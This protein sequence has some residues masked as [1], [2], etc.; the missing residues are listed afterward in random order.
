MQDLYFDWLYGLVCKK[1]K[2]YKKL[3]GRLHE[4][5]FTWTI[6]L[7]DNRASDGIGLRYRFG[8]ECGIHP[9][10]IASE[11]DICCCSVLEMLVALV[12]RFERD[13]MVN[14]EYGDRTEDWFWCIISNLG[15]GHLDDNNFIQEHVDL[16]INDVLRHRY[17][18][19][20]EGGYFYIPNCGK[21][22]RT[23]EIWQQAQLYF[24][25]I[26]ERRY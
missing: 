19:N 2:S 5:P 13:I 4:I 21:D 20:G 9:A 6:P 17:G 3:L 16:V 8:E 25:E 10:L 14:P 12:A 26:I 1:H 15:L 7:D 23:M 11:L 18:P 24:I 22:L